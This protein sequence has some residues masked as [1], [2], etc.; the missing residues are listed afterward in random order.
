MSGTMG[1]FLEGD[2]DPAAARPYYRLL[3]LRAEAGEPDGRSK[4][5]LESR[6]ELQNSRGDVHG[7]VIAS[8]LDAA[9]GVAVRSTMKAGEGATTVSLTVNYVAPGRGTL[10]ARGRVVRAGRTLASVEA[11]VTDA[12]GTLAAH[13]VSTMR[14][15][16]GKS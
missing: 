10:T 3:G 13:A 11:E 14:I 6:D 12:T 4:L 2:D 15:V 1:R 8:L 16:S 9:M 7:G 5:V